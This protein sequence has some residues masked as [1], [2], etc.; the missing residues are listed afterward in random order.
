MGVSGPAYQSCFNT[1]NILILVLNS[2]R[3]SHFPHFFGPFWPSMTDV[4]FTGGT[5]WPKKAKQRDFLRGR[6]NT[7]PSLK[8]V[9]DAPRCQLKVALERRTHQL[10]QD[11]ATAIVYNE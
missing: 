4:F 7:M 8:N 9:H 5:K 10:K 6:P 1:E 3:K 11:A 2:L